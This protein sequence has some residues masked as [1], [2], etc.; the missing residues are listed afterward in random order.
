MQIVCLNITYKTILTL[1][2]T[3][4]IERRGYEVYN[5]LTLHQGD[6]VSHAKTEK[7]LSLFQCPIFFG[8]GSDFWVNLESGLKI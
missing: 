6:L 5:V 8:L 3:I 2:Y 1:G 7:C 4:K